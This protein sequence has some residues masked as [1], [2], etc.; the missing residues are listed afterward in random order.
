VN[1]GV[2]LAIKALFN[3]KERDADDWKKLFEDADPRFRFLNV[4]V[5][6]GIPLAVIQAQWEPD[7]IANSS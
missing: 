6:P 2:D 4:S 5:A 3:G 7:N 1:R